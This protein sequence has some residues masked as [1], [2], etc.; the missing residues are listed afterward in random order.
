MPSDEELSH[1]SRAELREL[2]NRVTGKNLLRDLNADQ[3][4]VNMRNVIEQT[5]ETRESI[6]SIET[7]QSTKLTD[8]QHTISP[9]ITW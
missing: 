7:E 3:D 8:V 5:A 6:N 4:F 1:L 9:Q 2:L